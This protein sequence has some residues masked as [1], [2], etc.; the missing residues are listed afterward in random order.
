MLT[1]WANANY[2]IW[3]EFPFEIVPTASIAK[4]SIIYIV[5][6][7]R[8]N[9]LQSNFGFECLFVFAIIQRETIV[10]IL[11]YNIRLQFI[12]GTDT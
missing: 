9:Y 1:Y 12:Y 3:R 8:L 7:V 10:P 11:I 2:W 4:I 5:E 6:C